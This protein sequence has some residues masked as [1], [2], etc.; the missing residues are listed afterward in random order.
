MCGNGI[1]C[2]ADHLSRKLGKE[3][4]IIVAEVTTLTPRAKPVLQGTLPDTYRVRMG[5]NAR[6]PTQFRTPSYDQ[7]VQSCSNTVDLVELAVSLSWSGEKC[8]LALRGYLTYTGE[9]HLVFFTADTPWVRKKLDLGQAHLGTFFE[10]KK[11][12]S[13][14]ILH[15]L[16]DTL[17]GRCLEQDGSMGMFNPDEGINV[18]IAAIDPNRSEIRVRTYERGG[19]GETKACG[20]GAT[21]VAAIAYELGLI[22]STR[23]RVLTEGSVFRP[24]GSALAPSYARRIGELVVEKRGDDWWLEGPAN[25]IYTGTLSDWRERLRTGDELVMVLEPSQARAE[26]GLRMPSFSVVS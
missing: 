17:N 12:H 10:E 13:G 8:S 18:N 22:G 19:W 21:A 6:L 3:D 5:S 4:L 25:R 1:R 11:A 2:V 24:P 9:P 15:R 26:S 16:G 20:T 7:V 14:R 23:I